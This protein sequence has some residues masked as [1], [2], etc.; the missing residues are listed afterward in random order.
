MIVKSDDCKEAGSP[1]AVTLTDDSSAQS[2]GPP[3]TIQRHIHKIRVSTFRKSYMQ[4][5]GLLVYL[6]GD[7]KAGGYY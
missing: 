1:T 4:L 2:S 3:L 6:D 7:Q 5:W